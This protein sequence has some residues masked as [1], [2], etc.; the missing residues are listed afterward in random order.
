MAD[1]AFGDG[2]GDGGGFLRFALF[3][4][5]VFARAI[6]RAVPAYYVQNK[7]PQRQKRKVAAD[8]SDN[9][10]ALAPYEKYAVQYRRRKKRKKH[11]LQNMPMLEKENQ[12]RPRPRT[13]MLVNPA[14]LGL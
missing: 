11:P 13:K 5:P 6:F 7:R 9:R 1:S 10:P 3:F 8:K 12:S 14:N 2:G 4:F